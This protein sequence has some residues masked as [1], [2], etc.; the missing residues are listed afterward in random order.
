MSLSNLDLKSEKGRDG[1]SE[2]K[3]GRDSNREREKLKLG[4][5]GFC[6]D[7][8]FIVCMSVCVG[9]PTV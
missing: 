4:G 9:L 6:V 7:F 5:V 2:R 8:Y 3:R 1:E